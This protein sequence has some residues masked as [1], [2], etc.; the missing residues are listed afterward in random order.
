MTRIPD[1]RR[2]RAAGQSAS[3]T[4]RSRACIA[5]GLIACSDHSV[6]VPEHRKLPWTGAAAVFAV[7]VAAVGAGYAIGTRL[8]GPDVRRAAAPAPTAAPRG[9]GAAPMDERAFWGLMAQ[10]RKAADGDTGR[11]SE[12][13]EQRLRHL[14]AQ[15]IVDFQRI[16]HRLDE[17]L[18]S[19]DVWGAAFVIDDG[20]SDDCFRD[21]R[22]YLISLGEGAYQTA[23]RDPDALAPVVEDAEKGDWENADSVAGDAYEAVAGEDIPADDSDLSGP[24]RGRPWDDDREGALI[25]RYP[26]LAARFR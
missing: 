5:A 2:A 16:R 1:L 13:L 8:D 10:T 15:A 18:Y 23:L 7:V 19:W 14:P 21:F 9:A 20:C 22:A 26:R 25:G 3:P 17:G 11:Q 6:S 4:G 12:L 24:P